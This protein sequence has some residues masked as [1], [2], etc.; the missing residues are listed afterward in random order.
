MISKY[1]L[2]TCLFVIDDF[3]EQYRE[4]AVQSQEL[5]D[6]AYGYSEADLVVR[7]GYPFRQM[8]KFVL[9]TSRNKDEGND[10]VVESKDFRMEVKYLKTQ[11]SEYDK[12]S[13]K[14]HGWEQIHNDFNW[15]MSER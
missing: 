2:S 3:N 13:N 4:I 12:D 7:I 11:K 1:L 6:I 8:A 9:Q 5:I 10:I 14:S 15:L